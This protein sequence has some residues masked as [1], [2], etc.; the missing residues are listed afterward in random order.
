M[1]VLTNTV[2][3][4][5]ITSAYR[6]GPYELPGGGILDEYFDPYQLTGD[7]HR[8]RTVAAA[9]ADL[10]PAGTEAVAGPALAA[11]PLVAAVALHTGLPAAYLRPASKH[12]GTHRQT[13]GADLNGRRTVLLDDTARTGANLLLAASTLR[14]TGAVVA[15]AVCILDRDAGAAA[16]LADHGLS[17][18][19]LLHDPGRAR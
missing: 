2:L 3:A 18:A 19:A 5:L 13:E 4:E 7:P 8:L 1:T 14:E 15:G 9:L 6:T 17:L 10:L 11:V 12:H 16:L